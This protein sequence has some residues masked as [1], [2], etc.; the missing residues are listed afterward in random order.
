MRIHWTNSD[1]S[2][3]IQRN[4]QNLHDGYEFSVHGT[5]K[6]LGGFGLNVHLDAKECPESMGR[7]INDPRNVLK[8][9]V[10]FEKLKKERKALVIAT[11]LINV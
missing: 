11:R 8:T 5:L 1:L 6:S 2:T 7:Y 9:N 4:R 10:R 3:S